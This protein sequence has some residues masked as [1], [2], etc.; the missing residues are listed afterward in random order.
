MLKDNISEG[1]MVCNGYLEHVKVN[2]IL[3]D[4]RIGCSDGVA[5]E[6][7]DLD[8][9]NHPYKHLWESK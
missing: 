2:K 9:A 5:W 6:P 7:E 8:V 4:G 1:M 3:E